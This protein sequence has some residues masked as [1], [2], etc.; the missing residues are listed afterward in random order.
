V[1]GIR[2]LWPA[3]HRSFAGPD[4]PRAPPLLVSSVFRIAVRLFQPAVNGFLP[5]APMAAN[6]LARDFAYRSEPI[7]GEFSHS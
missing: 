2:W 6:L 4:P 3:A 5:E 1:L 7:I